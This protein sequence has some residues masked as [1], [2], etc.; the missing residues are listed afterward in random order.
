[1]SIKANVF[2]LTVLMSVFILPLA[3]PSTFGKDESVALGL[4]LTV[5][6]RFTLEHDRNEPLLLTLAIYNESAREIDSE[7]IRKEQLLDAYQSDGLLKKMGEG[8]K[9]RFLASVVNLPIKSVGFSDGASLENSIKFFIRVDG[10]EEIP[11]E[12][13]SLAG[14]TGMISKI[15]L[16][17]RDTVLL[18]YGLN[19]K[20][21]QSIK[22][23]S[24]EIVVRFINRSQENAK[25]VSSASNSV[26]LTLK[27]QHQPAENELFLYGHF[28]LLDQ[29]YDKAAEYA[30]RI[31]S[32]NPESI[33]GMQLK[34]DSLF[35]KEEYL[36]AYNIFQS[37]LVLY[38]QAFKSGKQIRYEPPNYLYRRLAKA[39]EALSNESGGILNNEIGTDVTTD[40]L[41]VQTDS[42]EKPDPVKFMEAAKKMV[43]WEKEI[44][45]FSSVQKVEFHEIV[46]KE[47]PDMGLDLT[48]Y[49]NLV[50]AKE[51]RDLN[52]AVESSKDRDFKFNISKME[53]K[54]AIQK[55]INVGA[56]EEVPTAPKGFRYVLAEGKF[57]LEKTE[58]NATKAIGSQADTP[59]MKSEKV[60]FAAD[61]KL[62][63]KEMEKIKNLPETQQMV[64]YEIIDE[65]R[66]K[67][68]DD[69][70]QDALQ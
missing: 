64:F 42:L 30:G 4:N 54:S 25:I 60:Q 21:L 70:S 33:A 52:A 47:Q 53:Y 12:V 56:I 61:I 58:G 41:A 49:A 1:M 46:I 35:G 65:L 5:Y 8:D 51:I 39:Q 26:K 40:I 27:N 17:A 22:K 31:L 19:S 18:E 11:L 55:L 69:N 7:N 14:N 9:K 24:F 36:K 63:F 28:Y 32:I 16:G 66:E 10:K 43:Q 13:K 59:R 37:A 6:D 3:S 50:V 34:G 23:E 45:R 48:V 67:Y 2:F 68:S 20:Q 62:I 57:R 44:E 38:E 29:N 15:Q